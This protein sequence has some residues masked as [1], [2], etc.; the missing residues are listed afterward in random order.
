MFLTHNCSTSVTDA[1]QLDRGNN[2]ETIAGTVCD[3]NLLLR[4]E[5][6]S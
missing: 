2:T 5:G 1:L 6:A 3:G 4:G